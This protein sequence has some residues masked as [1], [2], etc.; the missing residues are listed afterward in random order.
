MRDD[1]YPTRFYTRQVDQPFLGAL[2]APMPRE[3]DPLSL[4]KPLPNL[5]LLL[6]AIY[7]CCA[8]FLIFT[9]TSYA[10]SLES[11]TITSDI[12]TTHVLTSCIDTTCI[13]VATVAAR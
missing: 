3:L 4:Q 11:A 10:G 5:A 1:P 12:A 8:L 13:D 2:V 9:V 7:L 6:M